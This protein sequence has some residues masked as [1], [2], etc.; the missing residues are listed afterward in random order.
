VKTFGSIPVKAAT[1][2][3]AFSGGTGS[4]KRTAKYGIVGSGPRSACSGPS[5]IADWQNGTVLDSSNC[6][7]I[8]FV[9]EP[10][11]DFPNEKPATR[12]D[13]VFAKETL[14]QSHNNIAAQAATIVKFALK[15]RM[16][17]TL[18][19]AYYFYLILPYS[20]ISKTP[21]H[22]IKMPEAAPC[23]ASI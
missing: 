19:G 17:I 20:V 6:R 15:K 2:L 12:T 4:A 13:T 8:W 3:V 11:S 5:L 21:N 9:P 18:N 10:A 1:G 23:L 7:V 22:L 16:C 14:V